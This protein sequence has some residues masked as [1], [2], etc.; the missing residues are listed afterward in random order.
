LLSGGRDPEVDP[1]AYS[2]MSWSNATRRVSRDE[3]VALDEAD[4][5][6]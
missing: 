4:A 1:P 2:K 6:A 5:V 3:E